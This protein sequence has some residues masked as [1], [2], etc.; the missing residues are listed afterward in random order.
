MTACRLQVAIQKYIDCD[1]ILILHVVLLQHLIMLNVGYRLM[2]VNIRH[3]FF[4]FGIAFV[5]SYYTCPHRCCV[6]ESANRYSCHL[7]SLSIW[8]LQA[9]W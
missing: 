8:L 7:V 2:Y 5:Y 4:R 3:N 1:F 9:I 6:K